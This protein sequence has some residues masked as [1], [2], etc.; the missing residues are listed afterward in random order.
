MQD[1]ANMPSF[2]ISHESARKH[3]PTV[4]QFQVMACVQVALLSESILLWSMLAVK[5]EERNNK[6][7]EEENE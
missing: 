2:S 1:A 5:L 3:V 6:K 4:F 7:E